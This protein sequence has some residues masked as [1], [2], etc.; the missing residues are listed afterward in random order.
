MLVGMQR[1]K[2]ASRQNGP[3]VFVSQ[4]VPTFE[5]AQTDCEWLV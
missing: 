4:G 1:R 3:Y 2:K 5:T